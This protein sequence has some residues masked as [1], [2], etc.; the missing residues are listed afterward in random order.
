MEQLDLKDSSRK[1]IVIY[2]ISY[3]LIYILYFI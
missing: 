1:L 2:A 3:F